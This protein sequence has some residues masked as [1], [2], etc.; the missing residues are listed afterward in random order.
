MTADRLQTLLH[1]E[2]YWTARA[3][4]EQG[5]RFYRALG[6]ALEAADLGNRRRIYAAWTDELWEFYERG[7][8]LEAAE[9]EGAA[10]E[11]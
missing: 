3:L 11:G 7:L 10:G 6:E 8:R 1:A 5:S 2:T 9:R 4:R